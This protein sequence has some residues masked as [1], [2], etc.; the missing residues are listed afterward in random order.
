MQ[1]G[2]CRI[3]LRIHVFG[4]HTGEHTLKERDALS[5]PLIERRTAMQSE[6]DALLCGDFCKLHQAFDVGVHFRIISMIAYAA[7]G[8]QIG[9][10]QFFA[11][12]D[13]T[14]N[15]FFNQLQIDVIAD[16]LHVPFVKHSLN[17][18]YGLAIETAGKLYALIADF[19]DLI[20]Y[21]T[22]VLCIAVFYAD[23]LQSDFHG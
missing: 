17:L 7:E 22:H 23:H 16:S 5:I 20:K 21:F 14:L 3:D 1:P 8:N 2:K 11:F 19:A 12:V 9:H 10:A 6:L 18:F 13:M 15:V 4:R